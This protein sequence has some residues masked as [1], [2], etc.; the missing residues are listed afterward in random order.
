MLEKIEGRRRRGT[1]DEV[2]GWH[3][4]LDGHEFGWSP[5]AGDGQGGNF[6]IMNVPRTLTRFCLPGA[7]PQKT[8]A[9]R[10]RTGDGLK[11]TGT[12]VQKLRELDLFFFIPWY[13]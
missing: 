4:R 1:E 3:H 2:V 7:L 12:A 5:G 11:G 10:D 8:Q 9:V 13:L 6:E